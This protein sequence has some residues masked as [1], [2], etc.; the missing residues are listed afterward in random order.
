MPDSARWK[1]ALPSPGWWR[2]IL[3][4]TPASSGGC[5][6]RLISDSPPGSGKSSDRSESRPYLVGVRMILLDWFIRRGGRHKATE[7]RWK[8]AVDGNHRGN[9]EL[10]RS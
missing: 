2:R 7:G 9:L 10:C 4:S 6:H 3:S 5:H 8:L 1:R